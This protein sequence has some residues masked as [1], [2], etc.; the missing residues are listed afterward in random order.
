MRAMK[1]KR[2]TPAQAMK[3]KR[4]TT[5]A[6]KPKRAT[7]PAMKRATPANKFPA[8]Q[9]ARR[10]TRQVKVMKASREL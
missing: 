1:P 6:M 2:A 9:G 7:T 4:A 8:F 10:L 3:P 5:P